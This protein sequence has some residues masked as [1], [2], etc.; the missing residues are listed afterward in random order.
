MAECGRRVGITGSRFFYAY[1]S[2]INLALLFILVNMMVIYIVTTVA[3]FVTAV[4]YI[5]TTVAWFVTAVIY[6][7]NLL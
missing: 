5:V 4:I 2:L 1:L 7:C 6:I 3:W